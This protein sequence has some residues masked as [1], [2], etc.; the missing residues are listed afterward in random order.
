M[1][2]SKKKNIKNTKKSE[3]SDDNEV[4]KLI[5][6]V[7]VVTLIVFVFYGI[8]VL[9]NKKIEEDQTEQPAT[10]QYD[11]ILIGNSLKQPNDDYYVMIY[12]DE[13]YDVNLYGTYLSI[14]SQKDEAIRIY[15]SQLNNPINQRFKAEKSNLDVTDISDLKIKSSTLLKISD[16]KIEEAY[17][18]E[19]LTEYLKEISKT[20][21]TE[22]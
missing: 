16:G 6:L 11:E 8:T 20:D 15:K 10:I 17:E 12:D 14:Y 1:A 18:G 4:S 3:Y 2:N 21:E 13:D 22:E 19:Q 5:K 7:I 9:V